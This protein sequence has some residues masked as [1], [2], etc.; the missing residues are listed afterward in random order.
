MHL[1]QHIPSGARIV[2]RT[3]AGI[4]AV[5]GRMTYRDAIGHVDSWNGMRLRMVRDPAANGSRPAERL[6]IAAE[7]IV[8]FK[9]VPERRHPRDRDTTST[10]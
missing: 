3:R 1:P 7:D 8:A 9:P 6:D 4:D 2:V 10:S 5:T